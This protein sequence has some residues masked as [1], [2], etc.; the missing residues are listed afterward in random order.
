ATRSTQD[1]I[2]STD[3]AGLPGKGFARILEDYEGNAPA[4]P[5]RNGVHVL[6]DNRIPA[7]ATDRSS[8]P[9]GLPEGGEVATVE[10]RLIYRRV[11]KA[12]ADEK[13]LDLPDVVIAETTATAT[14]V[15]H[16]VVASLPTTYNTE[17]FAPSPAT[18]A[19][20]ER[21]PHGALS[22]PE[23]CAG[24]HAQPIETALD[25]AT[26]HSGISPAPEAGMPSGAGH[27]AATNSPLYRAWYKVASQNVQGQLG[28][29]CAGC[30]TPVGLLTGQIRTRWGWDGLEE[31]PLDEAAQTG[32]SCDVCHSIVATTGTGNGAYVVAPEGNVPPDDLGAHRARYARDLYAQPEFC[33]TC[34]EATNPSSGLPVMTTYT[35]WRESQFNTGKPSTSTTCQDCHFADGRHGELRLED[36]QRAAR[37]E[38][39]APADAPAGSEVALRVRVSNVGAGHDL[40]TGMAE[41]RKLWLEVTVTD[42]TGRSLFTSGATDDFGDPVQ[43]S[44]TYG[45]TW[46]DAEGR[47]TDRMWEAESILR[48]HRIAAGESMLEEYRFTL[49]DEALG[50]LEVRAA[51]K[52]RSVGGYLSSLMTIY[53]KE[54]VPAAPTIEMAADET[55][56]PIRSPAP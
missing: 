17:L 4:P 7:R 52:Y 19:S 21:L 36:L 38:L 54:E 2:R 34:H 25:V 56:L 49:P 42:A 12:W 40:P 14:P 28:A 5:W 55:A 53:L 30:H 29:F 9:F 3:Y 31:Y 1:A 18:T 46:R 13:G 15:E 43:G 35:E 11:F 32:V 27:G 39:L 8:Y 24:C 10:V 45:T 37:V 41:L 44:V 50:P 16:P 20:G 48:D 23:A 33:A 6:S 51:L 26:E 47:P 22:S